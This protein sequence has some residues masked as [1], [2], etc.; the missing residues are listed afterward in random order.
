[1]KQLRSM[2]P[3]AAWILSRSNPSA[4]M[5]RKYPFLRT[6]RI[7][8]NESPRTLPYLGATTDTAYNPHRCQSSSAIPQEVFSTHRQ[9]HDRNQ[10]K[11]NSWW[12]QV[13]FGFGAA[14]A[15]A[16]SVGTVAFTK[17]EVSGVLPVDD[18]EKLFEILSRLGEGGFSVVY[19]ARCLADYTASLTRDKLIALKAMHKSNL[20]TELV[21]RDEVEVMRAAGH[22][23]NLV[24]LH[25]VYETPHAYCLILDLA[26]GGALF[27]RIVKKG[28]LSE[29]EA[30]NY[31]LQV[32]E[33]L[34]HMHHRNICHGG[35]PHENFVIE[36]EDL[37]SF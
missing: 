3:S 12:H 1:M 18:I 33:A 35:S 28:R 36:T 19:K 6:K 31:I 30:S 2:R 34:L 11:R 5:A 26:D 15:A 10:T 7:F 13:A 16:A 8:E 4:R 23:E 24:A 37:P 21:M 17:V 9:S 25:G 32:T 20:E 22:H 27:D 29:A 14:A